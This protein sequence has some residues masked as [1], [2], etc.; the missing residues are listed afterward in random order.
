[1]AVAGL[2]AVAYLVLRQRD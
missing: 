2:L 1:F